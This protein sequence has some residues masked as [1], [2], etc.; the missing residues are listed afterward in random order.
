VNPEFRKRYGRRFLDSARQRLAEC[1]VC[2]TA[3]ASD[4]VI[5]LARTLHTIGGEAAMIGLAE[6]AA[7]ARQGELAA[8][9]ARVLGDDLVCEAYLRMMNDLLDELETG[10]E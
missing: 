3:G 1:A 10:L 9:R 5:L 6:I 4:A 8:Q 7:S 2:F